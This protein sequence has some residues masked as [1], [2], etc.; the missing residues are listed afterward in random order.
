MILYLILIASFLCI[1]RVL[2]GPTAPDRVIAVD[3]LGTLLVV[4]IVFL[5][6]E[7]SSPM[8]IDIA[9][10]Y[11]ILSFIGAIAYSKYLE[12]KKLFH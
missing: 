1:L 6:M 10:A 4:L 8:L 2:L 5:G 12:G 9:I 11:A 3:A 7:Y